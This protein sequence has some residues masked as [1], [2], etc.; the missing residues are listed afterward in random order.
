MSGH[1]PDQGSEEKSGHGY[2]ISPPP[3]SQITQGLAPGNVREVNWY[4]NT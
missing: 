2:F 3:V 4:L 1:P